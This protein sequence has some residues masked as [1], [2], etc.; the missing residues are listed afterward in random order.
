MTEAKM[1]ESRKKEDPNRASV[2]EKADSFF[3]LKLLKIC[4]NELRLISSQKA[5]LATAFVLAIAVMGTLVISFSGEYASERI[6]VAVFS[7]QNLRGFD[8]NA[9][10]A[11]LRARGSIR[12]HEY[13]SLA[14][15]VSSIKRRESKVGIIVHEPESATG[16]FVIDLMYDNSSPVSSRIFLELAE[17]EIQ[18]IGVVFSQKA[19]REVWG[20]LGEINSSLQG[21]T[22]KIEGLIE[23]L[24]QSEKRLNELELE[25]GNLRVSE[26]KEALKRQ[27]ANIEGLGSEL[28]KANSEIDYFIREL[29]GV[30]LNMAAANEKISGHRSELASTRN[31]LNEYYSALSDAES[32]LQPLESAPGI[33]TALERVSFAKSKL[34]SYIDTL[35]SADSDLAEAQSELSSLRQKINQEGTGVIAELESNKKEIAFLNTGTSAAQSDLEKMGVFVGSLERTMGEVKTLVANAKSQK[36]EVEGKLKK[37]KEM[38]DS[39]IA[40]LADFEK[41][42]PDFLSNPVIL[43]VM[44][45]FNV[46]R[47]G[48]IVPIA[49]VMLLMLTTILLTGVSFVD[50]KAQGAYTRMVL[51]PTPKYLIFSGKVLGQLIFALVQV[52]II[53]AFFAALNMVFGIRAIIAENPLELIGMLALVSV[54]F[55]TIG[56]FITNFTR[57]QGTT[58]LTALLIIV[59]ML[60]LSGVIIPVELINPAIQGFL[61]YLPLNSSIIL[62]SEVMIKG[63]HLGA[64][65]YEMAPLAALAVAIFVF[66]LLNRKL[67]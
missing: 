22:D 15:V 44:Q 48:T 20:R 49:L 52:A 17:S 51:S 2:L 36:K 3:G 21:E 35:D 66:T 38:M 61:N 32:Q 59:P 33:S 47:L 14:M 40:S 16:R 45:V 25:L 9:F 27:T 18:R 60:F 11:N 67:A 65:L 28:S 31:D 34:K 50:E 5:G 10:L 41:V 42:S 62:A 19:L 30:D 7:S 64:L 13:G 39:F 4:L 26:A 12:V 57:S 58:I 46:E 43:N 63:T 54:T 29:H 8:S 1:P 56:L 55:I 53:L 6:D 23:E 24:D 37:S